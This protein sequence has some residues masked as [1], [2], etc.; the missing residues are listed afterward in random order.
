MKNND[1]NFIIER[2]Y[3][4]ASRDDKYVA[5][6]RIV[7]LEIHTNEVLPQKFYDELQELV[8]KHCNP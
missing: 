5:D 6:D 3:P 1:A 7:R 2:T 8:N 4:R